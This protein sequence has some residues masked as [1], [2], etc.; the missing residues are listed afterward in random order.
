MDTTVVPAEAG[1]DLDI[2]AEVVGAIRGLDIVRPTHAEVNVSVR[3]GHVTLT[4]IV[5]SIF[6]A[7]EVER[8]VRAT[9]GVTGVTNKLFDDGSLTRRVA[10]ALIT[11]PRTKDI[12]PGYSVTCFFGHVGVIGHFASEPAKTAVAEVCQSIEGVRGVKVVTMN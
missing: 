12:P 10:H 8:A 11:D 7:I 3:Q 9:P 5:P 2:E 6:A 4:G 1:T